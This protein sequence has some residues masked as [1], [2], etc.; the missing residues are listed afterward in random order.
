M[1]IWPLLEGQDDLG[2]IRLSPYLVSLLLIFIFI[3]TLT[4][5]LGDMFVYL[6]FH[7][8]SSKHD[9]EFFVL[10]VAYLC[11]S[12]VGP[13][14]IFFEKLPTSPDAVN[15]QDR[16]SFCDFI[17]WVFFIQGREFYFGVKIVENGIV[18]KVE[19]QEF[20]LYTWGRR[21]WDLGEVK[22]REP[23]QRWL[24]IVIEQ[25]MMKGR[26]LCTTNVLLPTPK[27]FDT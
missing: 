18:K 22:K 11:L 3:I 23:D 4:V 24:K 12:R 6:E 26:V 16:G 25:K 13:C 9:F 19:S 1:H 17:A 14:F 8:V 2:N 27:V 10:K 7:W 5:I 20:A 15:Y 21:N